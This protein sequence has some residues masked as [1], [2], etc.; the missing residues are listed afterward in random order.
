MSSVWL[1]TLAAVAA[2]GLLTFS[3][4][5]QAPR[6]G[7]DEQGIKQMRLTD[8]Q[9]RS[10]ISAQKQISPIS[11]KIEAA[12]DKRDPALESQL[13]KIAKSNGFASLDE[14]G[15]VGAN[16]SMVLSG[17]DPQ[18]G[19][20]TELPQLIK[21]DMEKLKQNKKMPQK[22]REQALADMQEA[23][24]TAAPLQFKENIALV[25]KYQKELDQFLGGPEKGN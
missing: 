24:K 10:F 15:D 14:L 25:R 9:I 21:Q 6:Q 11:S 19:Q 3:G 2:L 23:L 13:E 16:I 22:D 5:A 20:F 7:E 18:T 1:R 4:L 12:G 17:L 8:K